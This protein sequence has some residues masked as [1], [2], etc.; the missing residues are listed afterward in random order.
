MTLRPPRGFGAERHS[1]PQRA[2][3][4][5]KPGRALPLGN[6][7]SSL[8][9]VAT[10]RMTHPATFIVE[11]MPKPERL[12]PLWREF[13]RTG[14]HS[15]FLSWTWIGTLLGL[16]PSPPLLLKAMRGPDVA[17]LALLMLRQAKIRGVLPVKQAWLNA[18]GDPNFDCVMLEHNGFAT[19]GEDG[20]A[21]LPSFVKWSA[22]GGIAA[23]E[24]IVPGV[25][26]SVLEGAGKGLI[27]VERRHAAYRT[28]LSG[29]GAG[30]LEAVISRNARQQLRRS[31]RDYDTPLKLEVAK[32]E[33]EALDIFAQ[34]KDL[35]VRSWTRRGRRHAFVSPFFETF[36]KAL[37]VTGLKDGSVELLRVTAGG[38]TL[39]CLYNFRRGG[40][41]SSYQSGFDDETPGLRPGYVCHAMA[42]EHY[43]AAGLT[44]YDFLAGSN[45]LKQSFGT[46][47]YELC[48]RH[49]RKPTLAFRAENIARKAVALIRRRAP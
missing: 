48:W 15:F 2:V 28:P 36:H 32:D 22:R 14:S 4:K 9:A 38:K 34:L 43:A 39:G 40:V 47:P 35:H 17:G 33:T 1:L 25:E 30:G 24:L 41:V 19:A 10:L 44:C 8:G 49:Y 3:L 13:D 23:G 11:P 18:T 46:E 26:P 29:I 21:L 5:M 12:A 16:L 45:R 37:I 31:R 20:T 42:M 27:V 7:P 6:A